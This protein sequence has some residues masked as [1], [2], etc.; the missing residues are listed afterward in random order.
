MQG[1]KAALLRGSDALPRYNDGAQR[2]E[3][4]AARFPQ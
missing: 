1:V 2:A 3:R 4:H